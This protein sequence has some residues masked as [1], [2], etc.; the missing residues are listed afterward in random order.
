MVDIGSCVD[1]KSI[2]ICRTPNISLSRM[3]CN[4]QFFISFY[5]LVSF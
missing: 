3:T 5:F 2:Y 4:F 1:R